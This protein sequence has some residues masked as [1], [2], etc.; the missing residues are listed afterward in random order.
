MNLDDSVLE[1]ALHDVIARAGFEAESDLRFD[2]L[3]PLWRSTALRHS[4]LLPAIG[5]LVESGSL[6]PAKP[7]LSE[8]DLMHW[9]LTEAG[10][11]RAAEILNVSLTT[12]GD[13]VMRSVL[14]TIR[15]R[16]SPE[17]LLPRTSSLR[18]RSIEG[19]HR[20]GE[21]LL[22]RSATHA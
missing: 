20:S 9:T 22:R 18:R 1:Y 10:A 15:D 6:V 8:E 2:V 7:K 19:R 4:D 21:R 5:M 13:Q 3:R 12:M 17:A 14:K 16:V 11:S